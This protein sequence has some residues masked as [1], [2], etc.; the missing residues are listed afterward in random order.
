MDIVAPLL[1]LASLFLSQD[2][3]RITTFELDS[4][5]FGNRRSILVAL[6]PGYDDGAQTYRV[7]YMLDGAP[8]FDPRAWNGPQ[9]VREFGQRHG[10][11]VILVG[12][13][14]GGATSTT[15]NPLA[16]RAG[17]YLPYPDPSWSEPPYPDYRGDRY[18]AFLL[19]EVH[20][21]I[22]RRYRIDPAEPVYLAGA[23]YG[24]IAALQTLLDRPAQVAA[25]ILESPSL[26]AGG[27]RL[28]DRLGQ[29]SDRRQ[30]IYV[31]VGGNEGET[32]EA[33]FQFAEMSRNFALRAI[34]AG[35]DV[36]FSFGADHAHW[37]TF[38]ADRMPTALEF[39]L[40]RQ[41]SRYCRDPRLPLP[42][43][44]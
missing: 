38:W 10:Q 15:Q 34:E 4:E 6:P 41:Q 7:I 27:D 18:P 42:G 14:N 26:Q 22:A 20:A 37:F 2:E 8:A 30:K 1:A 25:V 29:L 31:G 35:Y 5:V 24:A 19:D 33:A 40:A 43:A 12:V 13:N 16:D 21:G 44:E 32:A 11:P 28:A 9:I 39:T 17:E 36:C 3:P 23:S